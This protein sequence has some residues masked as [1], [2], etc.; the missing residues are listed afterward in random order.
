MDNDS[1]QRSE[2]ELCAVLQTRRHANKS[3]EIHNFM[4]KRSASKRKNGTSF[5]K[6]TFCSCY[7]LFRAWQIGVS[8]IK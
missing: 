8:G 1:A 5:E 4:V 6:K 3:E 7:C 2:S